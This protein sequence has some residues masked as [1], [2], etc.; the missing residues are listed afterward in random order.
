MSGGGGRGCQSA[1]ALRLGGRHWGGSTSRPRRK[2]GPVF[3]G[4]RE[5]SSSPVTRFISGELAVRAVISRGHRDPGD[6]HHPQPPCAGVAAAFGV[7]GDGSLVATVLLDTRTGTCLCARAEAKLRVSMVTSPSPRGHSVHTALAG[8]LQIRFPSLLISD[9][10]FTSRTDAVNV[11]A[12]SGLA[13]GA[14]F[15][16]RLPSQHRPGSVPQGR[17]PVCPPC[18]FPC[19]DSG[20][21]GR[22]PCALLAGFPVASWL[23]TEAPCSRQAMRYLSYLL[24]P[25]CIG[26][27]VYSLLNVKYKR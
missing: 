22:G 27:A 3:A 6:P 25:L 1:W 18:R 19:P 20:P 24:Y 14:S 16:R 8:R 26:G 13:S 15:C 5:A 23:V 10:V 7:P 4:G 11:R 2:A 12:A 21:Q 9:R 17:W